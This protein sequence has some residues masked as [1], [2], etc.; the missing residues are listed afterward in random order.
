MPKYWL[1][2]DR[3]NGGAG[4]G[5]NPNGLTYFVSDE[6]GPLSVI[7]NWKKVTSTQFRTLLSA[8]A[9][10]FPV[11]AQGDNEQQKHVTILVHGFNNSFSDATSFYHHLCD[12]LYSDPDSLGICV[13]LSLIHI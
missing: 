6:S 11:L 8:A 2:S 10:T 13:L 7:S 5:R 1:I 12:E 3:N 4:T 9:D